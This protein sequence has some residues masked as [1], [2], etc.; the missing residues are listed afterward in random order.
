MTTQ[1]ETEILRRID[2]EFAP[3]LLYCSMPALEPPVRTEKLL[4]Y[5]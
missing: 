4:I 3:R 1:R 2:G 5:N